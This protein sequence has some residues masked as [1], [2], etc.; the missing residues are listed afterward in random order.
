MYNVSQQSIQFRLRRVK[1]KIAEVLKR[2]KIII[3]MITQ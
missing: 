3:N 2:W 1:N